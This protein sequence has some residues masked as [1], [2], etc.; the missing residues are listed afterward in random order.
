[1]RLVEVRKLPM[2]HLRTMQG[3]NVAR[4]DEWYTDQ[5]IVDKCLDILQA[6]AGSTILCPFDGEQSKFVKTLK[7]SGFKVIY[8]ITDFIE[9]KTDY[10]CDF[11]VTNPPF[12]LKDQIIERVFKYGKKTVLVLPLDTMGGKARRKLFKEYEFPQIYVPE[13]RVSYYDKS[14]VKRTQS[15]FHSVIMTFKYNSESKLD[16]E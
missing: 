16:W 15:N 1:M 12:S 11:I 10:D 14:W 5:D 6:P 3:V 8:G 7:E 4:T 13:G 9:S 2:S